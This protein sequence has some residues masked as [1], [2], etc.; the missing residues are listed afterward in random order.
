MSPVTPDEIEALL[1]D[2]SVPW[3]ERRDRV[4]DLQGVTG[5]T[6]A[7]LEAARAAGDW[8]KFELFLLVAAAHPDPSYLPPITAALAL[9][10]REVP[11]EDA[12]E[13]LADL[14]DPG[15][16]ALLERIARTEH[17]WDEFNQVGVKAVW[18][19]EAIHTPEATAALARIAEHGDEYVQRWAAKAVTRRT[20]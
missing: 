17:E 8:G 9:G 20:R 15:T 12:L 18:A 14:P 3:E 10:A 5:A 16:I 13:V 19:L 11:N 6:A 4:K 7:G 1:R 2:P